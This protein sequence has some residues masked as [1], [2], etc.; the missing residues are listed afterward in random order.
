MILGT[1]EQGLSVPDDADQ[2]YE[3]Y[4]SRDDYNH[5]EVFSTATPEPDS[6]AA[7]YDFH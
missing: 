4:Y 2:D 6:A 7:E 1:N 5:F 3:G